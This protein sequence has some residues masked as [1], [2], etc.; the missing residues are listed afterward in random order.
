MADDSHSMLH[1]A[2]MSF[3]EHL[4]EL[5]AC[6]IRALIGIAVVACGTLFYGKDIVS[7]LCEPLWYAQRSVGEPTRIEFLNPTASLTI[8]LKVS[9]IAAFII[10]APWVLFQIWK[11]VSAG[12]YASEKRIAYYL[13]PLSAVMCALGVLFA[14]YVLIPVTLLFFFNFAGTFPEAGP[15]EASVLDRSVT[16]VKQWLGYETPPAVKVAEPPIEGATDNVAAVQLSVLATDPTEP[17][18][19]QM[20][21]NETR[22]ELRIYAQGRVQRLQLMGL[23][24]MSARISGDEYI[25]FVTMSGLGIVV[26]FQLP[27]VMLIIGWLGIVSASDLAR[28]RRYCVFG[29]FVLG[30][31]LT[32]QDVLSMFLLSIPLWLLFEFGLILMRLTERKRSAG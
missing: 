1:A 10:A 28:V 6:L 24:I 9:I 20:W 12:L 8:Y 7:W 3:G 27:V 32:P 22:G 15:T 5:R 14:Y 29:C 30:A 17:I 25:S 31:V 19:G 11:F 4:D 18:E 26:A 2:A 23:S 13:M 21:F 16:V